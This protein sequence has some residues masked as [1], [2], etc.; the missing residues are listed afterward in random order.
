MSRM[1]NGRNMKCSKKN[2]FQIEIYFKLQR[3]VFVALAVVF[4]LLKMFRAAGKSDP[5]PPLVWY[6]YETII[7][8]FNSKMNLL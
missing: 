1:I 3:L 7:N 8:I 2:P 5:P 4:E 6:Y